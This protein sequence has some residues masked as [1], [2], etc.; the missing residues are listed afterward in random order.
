MSRFF[1]IVKVSGRRHAESAICT[2]WYGDGATDIGSPFTILQGYLALGYPSWD[3][4]WQTYPQ[5]WNPCS[6]LSTVSAAS[7]DATTME[8]DGPPPARRCSLPK[9]HIEM[10][11]Q[12]HRHRSLGVVMSS[13]LP[14]PAAQKEPGM[15]RPPYITHGPRRRWY[16][17]WRRIC[18]CGLDAW[19]CAPVRAARVRAAAY[20][21][22]WNDPTVWL[23]GLTL[24]RASR[25]HS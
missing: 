12:C 15:R 18:R 7:R 20:R 14:R 5:R 25:H 8:G 19:P 1:R 2:G 10:Y 23:P 4:T 22:E 3:R 11:R 6:Y 16:R 21:H 24:R 17:P 13:A 9:H